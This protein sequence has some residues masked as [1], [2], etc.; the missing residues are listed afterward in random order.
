MATL[1]GIAETS[2]RQSLILCNVVYRC[3]RMGLRG[4]GGVWAR[5]PFQ[6]KPGYALLFPRYCC[7]CSSCWW[8]HFAQQS[9]SS[10][11]EQIVRFWYLSRIKAN[12]PM[13]HGFTQ[14]NHLPQSG[15]LSCIN[16]CS[17][18]PIKLARAGIPKH[19]VTFGGGTDAVLML[20]WQI[21]KN[22]QLVESQQCHVTEVKSPSLK[23]CAQRT[24]V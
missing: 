7:V 4:K 5:G 8:G 13:L 23:W 21:C 3:W 15:F 24:G 11:A 22:D 10:S 16:S 14:P 17:S 19:Q 1:V 20:A 2:Q 18:Y 12:M 9:R 6:I